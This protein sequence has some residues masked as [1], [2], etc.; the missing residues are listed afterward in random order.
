MTILESLNTRAGLLVSGATSFVLVGGGMRLAAGE[1]LSR[2]I[3]GSWS[4]SRSRRC[5][6]SS[7]TRAQGRD[8]DTSR[9][10]EAGIY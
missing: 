10:F 3:S 4:A 6:S 9:P 5:S 2:P 8:D 7:M 1:S